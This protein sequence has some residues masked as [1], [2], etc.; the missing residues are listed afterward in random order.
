MQASY[1]TPQGGNLGL[2]VT[3]GCERAHVGTLIAPSVFKILDALVSKV[4]DRIYAK[5]GGALD[6]YHGN[7][8]SNLALQ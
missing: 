3:P 8:G 5:E 4:I 7:A 2:K 6:T 1:L